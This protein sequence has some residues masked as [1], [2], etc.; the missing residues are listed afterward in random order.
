MKSENEVSAY[1]RTLT[2][3]LTSSNTLATTTGIYILSL[4]IC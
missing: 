3:R 4:I 2:E 1:E